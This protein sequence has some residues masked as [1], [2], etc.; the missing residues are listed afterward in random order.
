M[1]WLNSFVKWS[2]SLTINWVDFLTVLVILIGVVRGR[3]RGLSEEL[4]DAVQW[5]VIIVAGGL[6]YHGLGDLFEKPVISRLAYY[7]MSYLA[8]ALGVKIVFV[9]IKKKL[10]Q[11]MIESDIFGRFEYYG[12]MAAG[13]VRFVCVY[14]FVLSLLHA[15][16][17]S[18]EYLAQRA[19]DVDYNYGSDFFPHP[20]KMQVTVFEKSTTGINAKKYL[21]TLMIERT[22]GSSSGL[23]DNNSLARR[24]ERTIDAIMGGK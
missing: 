18:P 9:L 7:M 1:N 3:K 14:F 2:Q 13:A 24:N 10:G 19:K 23:R 16:H 11:K 5:V 12:G 15:P 6:L 20:S 22:S 4:L 17:Y 8:I 21:S